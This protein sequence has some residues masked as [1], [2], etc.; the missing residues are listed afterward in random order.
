M[1]PAVHMDNLALVGLL[2]LAFSAYHRE[3]VFEGKN[4]APKISLIFSASTKS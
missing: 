2:W 4:Q 1:S 3:I